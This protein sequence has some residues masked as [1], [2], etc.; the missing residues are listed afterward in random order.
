[1]RGAVPKLG[2]KKLT[3]FHF[4]ASH[5]KTCQDTGGLNSSLSWQLYQL[6]HTGIIIKDG[7]SSVLLGKPTSSRPE[8]NRI[9]IIANTSIYPT[10][11]HHDSCCLKSFER[12]IVMLDLIRRDKEAWIC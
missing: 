9:F 10:L 8:W 6:V 11:S 1:M 2:L 7:S 5:H 4:P 12:Y 3:Q